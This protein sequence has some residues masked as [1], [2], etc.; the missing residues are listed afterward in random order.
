VKVG[1]ASIKRAGIDSSSA[2]ERALQPRIGLEKQPYDPSGER[3]ASATG[4]PPR[5]LAAERR[6]RAF[7]T[8]HAAR[9]P[10]PADG[11]LDRPRRA[12]HQRLAVDLEYVKL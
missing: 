2:A 5:R 11:R 1:T 8:A 6:H 7:V 10:N 12:R 9:S 3:I 4:S